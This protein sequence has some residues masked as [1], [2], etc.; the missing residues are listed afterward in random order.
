MSDDPDV[1]VWIPF[2]EPLALHACT[3]DGARYRPACG[4]KMSTEVLI[5]C[6]GQLWCLRCQRVVEPEARA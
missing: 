4:S 6:I 2:G 1:P 5:D 3:W